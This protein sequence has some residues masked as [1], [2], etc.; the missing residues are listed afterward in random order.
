M[1]NI[2][3]RP[4]GTVHYNV[5]FKDGSLAN[6]VTDR[7]ICGLRPVDIAWV[8]NVSERRRVAPDEIQNLC[9]LNYE[10]KDAASCPPST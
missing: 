5:H 10:V 1:K 6:R 3:G 2:C 8:W 7:A 4:R 9:R